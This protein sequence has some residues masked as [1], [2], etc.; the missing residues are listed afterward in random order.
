MGSIYSNYWS[1]RSDGQEIE[2]EA[3]DTVRRRTPNKEKNT[4][5]SDEESVNFDCTYQ[6]SDD[7]DEE[8]KSEE[9]NNKKLSDRIRAE[10]NKN[11]SEMKIKW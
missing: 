1:D 2:H 4:A 7:N 5:D 9:M 11:S 10:R 3:R 8:P 6:E